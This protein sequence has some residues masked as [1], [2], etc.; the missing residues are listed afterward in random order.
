MKPRTRWEFIA[1][2]IV[3]SVLFVWATSYV[4]IRVLISIGCA[5]A[6]MVFAARSTW[7]PDWFKK[8][9][10]PPKGD[11]KDEQTPKS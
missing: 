8:P 6:C 10:N 5:G 4:P 11:K 7:N 3:L 2:W 9:V 1:G